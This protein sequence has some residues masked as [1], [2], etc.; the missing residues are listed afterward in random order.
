MSSFRVTP[1]TVQ[2][3][4]NLIHGYHPEACACGAPPGWLVVAREL[5]A[6]VA[7]V[8]EAWGARLTEVSVSNK[9]EAVAPGRATASTTTSRLGDPRGCKTDGA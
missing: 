5:R 3:E 9:R 4:L 8:A 2:H 7:R 6:D 1:R